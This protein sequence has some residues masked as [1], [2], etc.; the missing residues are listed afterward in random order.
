M[1]LRHRGLETGSCTQR[2]REGGKKE[3]DEE[4]RHS[5]EKHAGR[6]QKT[7][8]R[9]VEKREGARAKEKQACNE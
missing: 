3:R 6:K 2:A 9:Q 8:E 7:P 1:E 5:Y 4:H